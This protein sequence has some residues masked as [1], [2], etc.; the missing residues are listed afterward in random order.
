MDRLGWTPAAVLQPSWTR[1]HRQGQARAGALNPRGHHADC[2]SPSRRRGCAQRKIG[3]PCCCRP[4]RAGIAG[5]RASSRTAPPALVICPPAARW[6][7]GVAATPK[8]LRGHRRLHPPCLARAARSPRVTANVHRPRAHRG[9]SRIRSRLHT[10]HQSRGGTI[11]PTGEL[12][13]AAGVVH[14][15]VVPETPAVES[16]CA[17]APSR[18]DDAASFGGIRA[19]TKPRLSF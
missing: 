19:R 4:A 16:A 3:P 1:W 14:R 8:P 15:P 2:P 9:P 11:A 6:K 12:P 10:P 5:Q 17:T 7:P 18:R 13:T